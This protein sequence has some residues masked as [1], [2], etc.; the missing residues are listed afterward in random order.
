MNVAAK[1]SSA[2]ISEI[3]H[4]S[5]RYLESD[6]ALRSV[7]AD[8]Y[9]PKWDSPWWHMLL[10]HEMGE[11]H[12]IPSRLIESYIASLNRIP[13]KIFPIHPEDMPTGIDP[14]RGSPCHCQLGNVYQVL[15]KW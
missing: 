12:R 1:T 13:L 5:V 11:T 10:L 2:F 3:G 15:A 7:E 4:Q 8:P 6:V 14:Y 9:W